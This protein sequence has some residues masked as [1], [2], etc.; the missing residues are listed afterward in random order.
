MDSHVEPMGWRGREETRSSELNIYCN[1]SQ[2]MDKKAGV[3]YCQ[4]ILYQLREAEHSCLCTTLQQSRLFGW[5]FSPAHSPT[6]A[7][8]EAA[9]EYC[10]FPF[11]RRGKQGNCVFGRLPT[12]REAKGNLCKRRLVQLPPETRSTREIATTGESER[13]P[14]HTQ[15]TFVKRLADHF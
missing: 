7:L 11:F 6:D 10:F 9:H 13:P 5:L 2:G 15:G 8:T 12:P 4:G 1:W 3:F 14:A